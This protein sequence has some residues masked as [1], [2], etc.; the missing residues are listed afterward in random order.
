MSISEKSKKI[1]E[2]LYVLYGSST[3]YLFGVPPEKRQAVEAIVSC[4]LDINDTTT[5]EEA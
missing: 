5:F 1:T 2:I 4:V 3:G